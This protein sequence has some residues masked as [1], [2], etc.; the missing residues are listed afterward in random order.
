[1]HLGKPDPHYTS[2]PR[3]QRNFKLALKIALSLV[4]VLWFIL[5]ADSLFGFGLNRF[6]LRPRHVEGL[7]GIASPIRDYSRQ[8]VA[9]L[10]IAFP[11]GQRNLN[12]GLEYTV[13]LVKQTCDLVSSDL[14]YLKI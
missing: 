7:V 4:M 12:E 1:M 10:G 14:G 5:I 9:A 2:S 13:G 8:V 11:V 6:G 3:A